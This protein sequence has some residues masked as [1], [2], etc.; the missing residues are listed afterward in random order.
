M[1]NDRMALSLALAWAALSAPVAQA[2]IGTGAMPMSGQ[3]VVCESR[4]DQYR[5]CSTPFRAPP[6]LVNTLSSSPCEQGRSWGSRGPGMVWVSNGCRAEF[7]GGY[8]PPPRP[9]IGGGAVPMGPMRCESE[10]GSYRECPAPAGTRMMMTRQ[11]SSTT[12]VEG[13]NWGNR[14][15]SVWVR[16]GCRAEFQPAGGWNPPAP[17]FRPSGRS[18]ECSSDNRMHQTC[19]WNP[20]WGYP[21]MLEQLSDQSC[22]EGSS[23]GYDGRSQI[24]VDRGCRAR[25]SGN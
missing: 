13:R 15:A 10:D 17:P 21:R 7:G 9:D 6:V 8:A 24:W 16:S 11:L 23:W 20:R 5:E 18:I 25:F 12:C 2:Q 22:R 1:K 14:Y 3:T 4:G 19:Y